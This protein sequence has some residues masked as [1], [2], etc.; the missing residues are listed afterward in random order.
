MSDALE[1]ERPCE[2]K[3]QWIKPELVFL[4]ASST[5]SS[6]TGTNTESTMTKPS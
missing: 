3:R 2:E 6:P 1:S 4:D 5:S